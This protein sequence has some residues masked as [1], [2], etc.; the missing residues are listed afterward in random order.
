[1][2]IKSRVLSLLLF[3]LPGWAKDLSAHRHSA[4]V[5]NNGTKWGI[6]IQASYIKVYILLCALQFEIM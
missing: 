2:L 5:K 3:F 6:D 4:I 1:M